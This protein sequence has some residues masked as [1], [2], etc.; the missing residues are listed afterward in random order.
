V[1]V[2]GLTKLWFIYYNYLWI[3]YDFL[4]MYVRNIFFVRR[5]SESVVDSECFEFKL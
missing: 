3:D 4:G 5:F 2:T 1:I